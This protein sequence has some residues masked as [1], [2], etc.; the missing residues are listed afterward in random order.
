MSSSRSLS[1]LAVGIS[2]LAAVPILV[3][4]RPAA[5]RPAAPP[6]PTLDLLDPATYWRAPDTLWVW[7]KAIELGMNSFHY[8]ATRMNLLTSMGTRIVRLTLYVDAY[9]NHPGDESRAA[10][11]ANLATICDAGMAPLV[12][13]HQ[14]EGMIGTP[15]G[16]YDIFASFMGTV[17]GRYPCVKY[18]QLFNEVD[19][20][21]AGG[22]VF[23]PVESLPYNKGLY[24][25]QM[26]QKAYP[27]IKAAGTGALVLT[28]GTY[29]AWDNNT[30]LVGGIYDGGGRQY[31]DI[32]AY[33]HYGDVAQWDRSPNKECGPVS[34]AGIRSRLQCLK[35][36]L[37]NHG[38]A[39]RP[40]W[41]TEFGL[42]A[43]SYAH[44]GSGTPTAAQFDQYQR[45]FWSETVRIADSTG[46]VQKLI[47]FTLHTD[48]AA[49]AASDDASTGF[50][51]R[52]HALGITRWDVSTPRPTYYYLKDTA[53]YN[54]HAFA[55]PVVSG[56]VTVNAGNK[57]PVGLTYVRSGPHVTFYVSVS[58]F[59]RTAVVFENEPPVSGS[60]V[61]IFGPRSAQ[62][63]NVC[64]WYAGD[65][66]DATGW[67]WRV[68]GTVVGT[69]SSLWLPMYSSFELTVQAWNDSGAV[70]SNTI[71]VNVS[72]E[73]GQCWVE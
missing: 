43:A 16:D 28:S 11:E 34:G 71:N 2:L 47:G 14:A 55:Y 30:S 10:F 26:L 51:P 3:A 53:Q 36:L 5:W 21:F 8:D 58:K 33:H 29:N 20:G 54:A 59:S 37:E 66:F 4:S 15:V 72:S 63:N 69:Q 65:N 52:D 67:E 12:V 35:I 19:E 48:E 24:Y 17:A 46:I 6:P 57:R 44:F 61:N 70:A 39:G 18:W 49:H 68:D 23:G 7:D 56:W 40:V 27:A 62:P 50:E 73:N 31:F 1:R 13:V 60:A 32:L 9:N 42:G 38:D 64:F 25:A 22:N 45:Q 41:I